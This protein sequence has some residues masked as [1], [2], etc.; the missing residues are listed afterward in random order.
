LNLKTAKVPGIPYPAP[1]ESGSG[2]FQRV[3]AQHYFGQKRGE[4]AMEMG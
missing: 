3:A 4:A 1:H 2:T